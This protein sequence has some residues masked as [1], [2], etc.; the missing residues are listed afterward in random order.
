MLE[1]SL[2][3]QRRNHKY[4]ICIGTFPGE[5]LF[6]EVERR[7]PA[8]AYVAVV[9]ARVAE[10]Y[11][12]EW[13][14]SFG[15]RWRPYR[16]EAGEEHKT[17]A[18]FIGLAE[19]ILR[20][21]IDRKTVVVAIGGGVVGD[22]AGFTAATLLRGIPFVQIPTTLL[23]Q[24]D[25]SVGGKTGINMGGGKNLLG[26][27]YQPELVVIDPAFLKTLS[28]REYLSGLAEVVKYGVI[29]D[30]KFFDDLVRRSGAVA[31]RDAGTL[32][33]IVAHCC[34]MKA[35]IVGADE[36]ES[37]RRRLLNLGHTFGHALE[38]LAGYDGSLLHGEAV[39]IGTVMAASFAMKEGMMPKDEVEAMQAGFAALELP[40]GLDDMGFESEKREALAKLLQSERLVAALG[41]DKKAAAGGMTLI[42]P[43]AIGR[44]GIVENVPASKIAEHIRTGLTGL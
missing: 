1:I 21:G 9:D 24:V 23:A 4:D 19:N 29:G 43:V 28:K 34:G 12:P 25:S 17:S 33:E 18:D 2:E 6:R 44:C 31:D 38:A 27:F 40:R 26:A 7:V 36:K 42:V 16:I 20:G 14:K 11:F 5:A 10:L 30:R 32:A 15:E 22:L 39:A 37:A 41:M 13:E 8:A 35:E 3:I